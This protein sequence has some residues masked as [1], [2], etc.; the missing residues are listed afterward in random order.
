MKLINKIKTNLKLR[1]IL[2]LLGLSII[3]V[4]GIFALAFGFFKPSTAKAD[5][6]MVPTVTQTVPTTTLPNTTNVNTQSTINCYNN[7][8]TSST[9]TVQKAA[10]YSPAYS[11]NIRLIA[12]NNNTVQVSG[13]ILDQSRQSN[14]VKIVFY[15]API[16]SGGKFV[17]SAYTNNLGN[18]DV[19]LTQYQLG[20][21]IAQIYT[22]IQHD[23]NYTLIS[24]PINYTFSHLDSNYSSSY[25]YSTDGYTQTSSTSFDTTPYYSSTPNYYNIG[26]RKLNYENGD[27]NYID[28]NS[29][30]NLAS[31]VQGLADCYDTYA[32]SN[33]QL[34]ILREDGIIYHSGDSWYFDGNQAAYSLQSC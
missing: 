32:G 14:A 25:S 2:S 20:I 21:S 7:C 27:S 34:D 15:N 26:T 19:E 16:Y 3:I 22:Y 13:Q 4:L 1:R 30:Y 17:N 11:C 24:Q 23:G 31:V 10:N 8:Q 12:L 28:L 29:D 33:Y 5:G 9:V 6:Y 18:F